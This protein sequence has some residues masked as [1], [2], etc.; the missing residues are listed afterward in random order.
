MNSGYKTKQDK[1]PPKT[2]EKLG[3]KNPKKAN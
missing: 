2:K 1:N 3:P